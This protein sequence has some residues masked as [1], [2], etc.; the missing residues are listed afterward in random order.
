MKTTTNADDLAA[1]LIGC[2]LGLALV[3]VV[4]MLFGLAVI[5]WEHAL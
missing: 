1:G 3:A 4:V 5:V 2:A